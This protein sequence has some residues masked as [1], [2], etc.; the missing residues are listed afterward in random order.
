MVTEGVQAEVNV[1]AVGVLVAEPTLEVLGDVL[2]RK[3]F[4]FLGARSCWQRLIPTWWS[5]RALQCGCIGRG[6]HVG[7][8]LFFF[9]EAPHVCQGVPTWI[10][11]Y[12]F[13]PRC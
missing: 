11:S 6:Q 10:K 8:A 9:D 7:S 4:R 12:E 5:G 13:R 2:P 1:R 3:S